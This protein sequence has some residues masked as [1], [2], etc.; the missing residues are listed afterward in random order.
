VV[1]N[2]KGAAGPF[3]ITIDAPELQH[4][5]W[6]AARQH[7][8]TVPLRGRMLTDVVGANATAV[9]S[10]HA[11]AAG[12]WQIKTDDAVPCSAFGPV[13]GYSLPL[14]GILRGWFSS[15]SAVQLKSDDSVLGEANTGHRADVCVD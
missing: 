13:P 12:A 8:P 10:I 15:G 1:V 6:T 7:G 11:S 4:G 2:L 9:Y 5:S 3:K 14:N